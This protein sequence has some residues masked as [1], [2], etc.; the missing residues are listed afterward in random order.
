[1]LFN[2]D[3][4][5]NV[6]PV[7]EPEYRRLRKEI[8]DEDFQAV[9]D[10][11]NVYCCENEVFTSSHIPGKNWKSPYVELYIAAGHDANLARLFFG[12]I[13]WRVVQNRTEGWYFRPGETKA[14]GDP[15]GMTYWKKRD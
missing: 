12:Q 4:K 11:L 5:Q 8:S 15:M 9:W 6:T 10:A 13:V 3:G 1:M 7:H 2:I 14:N